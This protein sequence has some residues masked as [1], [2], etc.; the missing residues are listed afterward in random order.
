MNILITGATGLVGRYLIEK[1]IN[2]GKLT[3]IKRPESNISSLEKYPI[4]WIDA[5]I[6]DYQA[7]EE[8]L[9]GID[10][11]IHAA[12]LV[13]YDS[14]DADLLVKTNVE[15]TTN[16][17]NAM[18][19]KGIKK[20]IHISSVAALGR[21]PEVV[22][23]DEKHKWIESPLNTPYAISKYQAD[24]EVWRA[25]QEGL[26]VMVM[27]PSLVLGKIADKRSS[28]QVYQYVIQENKYYPEGTINYV[29]VRDLSEAIYRLYLTNKWGENYIINAESIPYK[30]FFEKIALATGKRAP[31]KVVN[32][33]SLKFLLFFT[34]LM[35]ALGWHNSPLN[36]QT[37]TLAQRKVNHIND[38]LLSEIPITFH[39]LEDTIIWATGKN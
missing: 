37:A 17:V 23:I 34:R 30:E 15:G 32:K 22:S 38:K 2:D 11:V 4:K 8:A 9:E 10:M 31:Y 6:R 19:D 25:A 21:S 13:S 5:D 24:L 35:K 33:T 20:L 39:K 16:L 36:A 7:L 1:F 14:R 26:D 18:L 3:A 27:Y 29:D 12:A 28:T